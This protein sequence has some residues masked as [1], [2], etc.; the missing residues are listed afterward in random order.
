MRKTASFLSSLIIALTFVSCGS[1]SGDDAN[2]I[3][4]SWVISKAEGSMAETYKGVACGFDKAN[5]SFNE[6]PCPYT[7]SNDTIVAK[8]AVIDTR[9]TYKFNGEQ[10]V[11]SNIDNGQVWYLDKKQTN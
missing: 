7:V 10:L 8:T 3:E 2:S 9:Y 1:G 11:L 5:M 4:G 6:V